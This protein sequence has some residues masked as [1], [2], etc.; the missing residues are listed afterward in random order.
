MDVTSQMPFSPEFRDKL[1]EKIN[2]TG[3]DLSYD[4][5]LIRTASQFRKEFEKLF[6][7]KPIKGKLSKIRKKV[8]KRQKQRSESLKDSYRF[9]NHSNINNLSSNPNFIAS[10]LSQNQMDIARNY[11]NSQDFLIS[12]LHNGSKCTERMNQNSFMTTNRDLSGGIYPEQNSNRDFVDAISC[13]HTKRQLDF[14]QNTNDLYHE[15]NNSTEHKE[16]SRKDSFLISPNKKMRIISTLGG[17]CKGN[18]ITSQRRSGSMPDKVTS[19]HSKKRSPNKFFT[20]RKAHMLGN[21]MTRESKESSASA[22][23]LGCKPTSGKPGALKRYCSSQEQLTSRPVEKEQKYRKN[24]PESQLYNYINQRLLIAHNDS[25]ERHNCYCSHRKIKATKPKK[26]T[27]FKKKIISRISNNIIRNT[28]DCFQTDALSCNTFIEQHDQSEQASKTSNRD[29]NK[30]YYLKTKSFMFKDSAKSPKIMVDIKL[31]NCGIGSK[32]EKQPLSSTKPIKIFRNKSKISN[33]LKKRA[34]GMKLHRISKKNLNQSPEN[35]GYITNL[36]NISRISTSPSQMRSSNYIFERKRTATAPKEKLKIRKKN[37]RKFKKKGSPKRTKDNDNLESKEIEIF[38]IN[39]ENT[40]P[41]N[42]QEYR[43]YNSPTPD[44]C[45][46]KLDAGFDDLEIKTQDDRVN[47]INI[48]IDLKKTKKVTPL[49]L[50][51]DKN[52]SLASNEEEKR[53]LQSPKVMANASTSP[54]LQRNAKTFKNIAVSTKDVD[55]NTFEIRK[56]RLFQIYIKNDPLYGNLS[57]HVY[58]DYDQQNILSPHDANSALIKV[59]LIVQRQDKGIHEEI[60]S[61]FVNSYFRIGMTTLEY[62]MNICSMKDY[63]KKVQASY[64]DD[65][66]ANSIKTLIRIKKMYKII[67]VLANIFKLI[68]QKDKLDDSDLDQNRQLEEIIRDQISTKF[69]EGP[70]KMWIDGLKELLQYSTNISSAKG[71][72]SETN[73]KQLSPSNEE[74]TQRN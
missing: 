6:P 67:D 5:K 41:D 64:T 1:K 51:S 55:N 16:G 23:R 15:L 48:D 18:C 3:F 7:R 56:S 66:L 31:M 33:Y 2:K 43:E 72:S 10:K 46:S 45:H 61:T 32:K 57:E 60:D 53:P 71:I 58:N 12:E 34:S 36:K 69:K 62:L 63:Y 59:K 47:I 28:W 4:Q 52:N 42:N 22:I 13:T 35:T 37:T 26:I 11:N 8:R 38:N 65:T 9:I 68:I 21:K 20:K 49:N 17:T 54:L 27:N 50:P 14:P 29:W 30:R 70:F 24:K 73:D 25:C 74:S 40:T 44:V 39:E 19:P